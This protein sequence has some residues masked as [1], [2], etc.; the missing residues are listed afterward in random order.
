MIRAASDGYERNASEMRHC[1][2]ENGEKERAGHVVRVMSDGYDDERDGER[3]GKGQC[4]EREMWEN[5]DGKAFSLLLVTI[6]REYFAVY[7]SLS[8]SFDVCVCVIVC[9]VW[10]AL[11]LF[12]CY[13]NQSSLEE[14]SLKSESC[15]LCQSPRSLS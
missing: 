5:E 10:C 14:S 15:V 4:E 11:P 9:V 7:I 13:S 1:R 2:R 8:T 3:K 12:C 6:L